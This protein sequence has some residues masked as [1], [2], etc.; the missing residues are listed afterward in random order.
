MGLIIATTRKQAKC[1]ISFYANIISNEVNQNHSNWNAS[2]MNCIN[3]WK[4][5][6]KKKKKLI[7]LTLM[8]LYHI[9]EKERFISPENW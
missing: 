7:K 6:C 2:I 5:L 3:C 9:W 4:I 8:F 1:E